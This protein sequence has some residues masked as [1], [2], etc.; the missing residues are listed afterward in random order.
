MKIIRNSLS[1]AAL[2]CLIA[3]GHAMAGECQIEIEGDDQM[4]FNKDE[5][6]IDRS[7][8]EI[9]LTLI[10]TGELDVQAMGHNVVFTA[11]EDYDGL[12][13]DAMEASDDDY[14]PEGDER[15]VAATDLIGGG[16]STTLSFSPEKFDAD[17]SYLFF[18]SFPGHAAPM[19]GEV[20]FTD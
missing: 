10:H 1:G 5:L 17:E 12:A 15:V 14:V 8:D 19:Q 18:C 3:S 4:Q 20:R 6:V 11:E 16:E 13:E 9:E 2:L 7:C